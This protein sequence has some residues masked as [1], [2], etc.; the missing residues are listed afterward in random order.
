MFLF[1]NHELGPFIPE[2]TT[3]NEITANSTLL[4][5]NTF[6]NRKFFLLFVSNLLGWIVAIAG[7]MADSVIAGLFI[8]SEAVAGVGLITPIFTIIYFFS[9]LIS[10]GIGIRYSQELGALHVEQSRK[11]A[12][13][14]IVSSVALG[15]FLAI[16][17]IVIKPL[18]LGFYNCSP[19]I[20]EYASSYYNIFVII[21]LIYPLQT[22]IYSLVLYDGDAVLILVSD[23]SVAGSNA[24][25]S[26]ILVQKL[27][28]NG[29]AIGTFS[30]VLIG[31][32]VLIPHFFKKNNSIHFTLNFKWQELYKCMRLSTSQSVSY[33]YISITHIFFNKYIIVV[34]GDAYLPAY[35]VISAII[36]MLMVLSSVG[37]AGGIFISVAYGENN[38]HAIRRMVKLLTKYGA[39]LSIAATAIFFL[40]APYWSSLY[41]ITDPL[42]ADA[43]KTAGYMLAFT[44]VFSYFAIFFIYYYPVINKPLEGNVLTLLYMLFGPII[45]AAPLGMLFGFD[46]MSFGMALAPVFALVVMII[47]FSLK[48]TLKKAPLLLDESEEKEAHYDF[49]L[50]TESILEV[51]NR[52]GK[53]LAEQEVDSKLITQ[54]EILLE[55]TLL[56]IM[57]KNK[58]KTLCDC[59]LLVNNEHVRLITKDNGM[60]FDITEDASEAIDFRCYVMATIMENTSEK[61]NTTTITFNRNTYLWER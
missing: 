12:G 58:K 17:L 13:I 19:Q 57:N 11:I 26:L 16:I 8:N 29:L 1:R 37:Y 5:E 52:A 22:T 47:L 7:E 30:S 32:L 49:E 60:I 4:K 36:N 27:G 39:V 45:I 33:L 14:G 34:F 9:Y 40:I 48:K 44:I 18:V 35:T 2:V 53:F 21:A 3:L 28:V 43:C 42:I 38:P 50:K 15:I 55:D 20:M 6:F 51:R 24:A 25:I 10:A 41:G 46:A 54:I 59:T 31:A 56:H 61:S 23:F